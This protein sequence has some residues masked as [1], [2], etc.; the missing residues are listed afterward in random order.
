MRFRIPKFSSIVYRTREFFRNEAQRRNH[1]RKQAVIKN[2]LLKLS[3]KKV[4]VGANFAPINGIGNHIHAIQ[5]YS[6]L[7]IGL[8]PED[9]VMAQ[10]SP[11]H[12]TSILKEDFNKFEPSSD[13]I[14]HSH[15]YPWYIH[16]CAKQQEKGIKWIH[17]YHAHYFDEYAENGLND[18]QKEFNQVFIHTASKADVKI[19]VSKWQ[20]NYYEKNHG[21][22]TLYVPNGIDVSLCDAAE[23]G[24]FKK[25]L[26]VDSYILNVSRHDIVKN[27]GEFLRLAEIM[28]AHQFV[29]IGPG[30]SKDVFQTEYDLDVPINVIIYG[31]AS[32]S[33]VQDAIAGCD[34][35]ISNSK[36]EGLPT[37]VLEGMAHSKPV[38]VSNEPG[39]IEAIDHGNY[40][41]YYE[42][43][44]IQDLKNKTIKA[45]KDEEI[46]HK[47]RKRV[48]EE[49][50]WRVVSKKLDNIYNGN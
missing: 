37:L 39:S 12:F 3:S 28:P 49:Y 18:W 9:K 13:V 45:L 2:W 20:Q 30:L 6:T 14:L 7:K 11:Y 26:G 46:G 44:D 15:V 34:V 1:K 32:H 40:G 36:R 22:Q 21:I 33:K 35:L 47:A 29:I 43:G 27:P 23:G 25:E 41:Y 16:W 4:W 42:L 31:S 17:T 48:L 50:D 19:S 24:N 10:M 5:K 38:V 8:F